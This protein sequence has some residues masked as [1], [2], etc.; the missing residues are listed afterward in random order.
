MIRIPTTQI[1]EDG[2]AVADEV[3]GS[4]L[5]LQNDPVAREA[6]PIRYALRLER[7]GE[8]LVVRG[9]VSA[10]LRLRC[11]RCAQFFSTTVQVS[12]FLHAY[13]WAAHPD[14]LDVSAEVREDVILEI[15]GF[16]LCDEACQGLCPRCGHNMNEGPCAC[17]PLGDVLSPWGDLDGLTAESSPRQPSGGAD[18][19]R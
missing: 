13:E 5:D 1:G 19:K 8:E 12:S 18:E 11:S 6:G 10:P 16:P 17:T 9:T 7:V 3:P 15:P 2:V 14:F 4:L